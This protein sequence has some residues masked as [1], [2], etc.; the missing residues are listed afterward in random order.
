[1]QHCWMDSW[2]FTPVIRAVLRPRGEAAALL[3][4]YFR[5]PLPIGLRSEKRKAA[6]KQARVRREKHTRKSLVGSRN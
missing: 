2:M 1:M 5:Q 3:R 4:R 6:L